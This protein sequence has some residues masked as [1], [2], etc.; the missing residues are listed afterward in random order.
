[1]KILKA[2]IM[3]ISVILTIG[4]CY[5]F[6]TEFQDISLTTS[7][8]FFLI[9][10]MIFIP[11]WFLWIR[12]HHFFSTFEHELTHLLVALLFL[13]KPAGFM[14]TENQG[15]V[16]SIYGNNFLITLAPYFLPTIAFL[17]LPVYLIIKP[18]FYNYLLLI[19]G[20][21]TSYHVFSTIQEFSY[22]QPDIIQSGKAFSTV[23]LIF[24]NV[25]VYGY[26]LSFVIGGFELGWLFI[27]T[28]F[29]NTV[30]ILPFI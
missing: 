25:F 18:E 21:F 13:K 11:L 22:K 23:F 2:L 16:T 3:L 10:F 24:A 8:R 4:Y 17:M 9:G 28:G 1:V 15:G 6:Y 12:N 7:I 19:I 27:K 14:V 5:F 20:Y 30:N 26:L 29:M